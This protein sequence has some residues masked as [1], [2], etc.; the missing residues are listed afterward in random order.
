MAKAKGYQVFV[1]DYGTIADKFKSQLIEKGIEFEEG[2][3][4][5]KKILTSHLVIKSPGIAA[6][7]CV[8]P[9]EKG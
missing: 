7:V 5:T 8:E 1:S 3:H 6:D 9:K 2:G 4:S